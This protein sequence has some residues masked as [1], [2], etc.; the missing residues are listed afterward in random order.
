MRHLKGLR[1][2]TVRLSQNK[3]AGQFIGLIPW[4]GHEMIKT[5]IT[6]LPGRAKLARKMHGDMFD[7][8]G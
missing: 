5:R 6:L 7:L 4:T 2:D 1:S 8:H 3:T